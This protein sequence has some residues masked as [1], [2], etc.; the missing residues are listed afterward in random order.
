MGDKVAS[1]MVHIPLQELVTPRSGWCDVKVDHWW[2]YNPQEDTVLFY[3]SFGRDPHPQCN[4]N[5][6]L[7]RKLNASLWESLGYV[8]KLVPVAFVPLK[9]RGSDNDFYYSLSSLLKG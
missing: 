8:I 3:K 5:E 4:P 9:I 1:R 6:V 2:V 7:A